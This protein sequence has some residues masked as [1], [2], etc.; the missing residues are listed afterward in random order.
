LP[1]VERFVQRFH[2]LFIAYDFVE[3]A[4]G[5]KLSTENPATEDVLAYIWLGGQAKITRRAR[6]LK[7]TGALCHQHSA[8]LVC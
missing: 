7:R 8:R 5:Q 6:H 1:E 4:S 2:R 3:P